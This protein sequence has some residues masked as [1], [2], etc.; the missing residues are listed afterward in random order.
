[1]ALVGAAT[2]YRYI[3]CDSIH[4]KK[5]VESSD[6]RLVEQLA[7]SAGW[8]WSGDRWTCPGC[9]EKWK[10]TQQPILHVYKKATTFQ[11]EDTN[12]DVNHITYSG[13][14]DAARDWSSR[15]YQMEGLR[16]I[17]ESFSN[18]DKVLLALPTGS[19][20]TFVAAKWICDHVL[21]RGGKVIW[22]AHRIELLEQAYAT[23]TRLLHPSRPQRITWWAGGKPK[24]PSGNLVFVSIMAA[25][26]F[27]EMNADLLVIDEAHHE[28]ATT[29][30]SLQDVISSKKHLGLTATPQRLD[31]K[32]LGY[33]AIAYQ[34]TFMSLVN[35]GW[36]ARPE[37]VVPRTGLFFDLEQRMDDFSNDSL[38]RL[39]TDQRNEFI[40]R[41]WAEHADDYGKTLVFALNRTHARRLTDRFQSARPQAKVEYI[42]SGEGTATERTNKI[43]QF[44]H[45]E[46]DVL[47]NCMIFTEGFDCP[48]VK[49]ILI[50]RPTLSTTLYS[51]MVGRGSRTTA[52]K[53]FFYLVDFEDNLGK[54]QSTLIRPWILGD[55]L[56]SE[57]S[58]PK[59]RNKEPSYDELPDWA[60][61]EVDLSD[62]ELSTIAGYVSY[63]F[64]SGRADGF[65]VHEDDEEQFEKV[66]SQL[67]QSARLNDEDAMAPIAIASSRDLDTKRLSL[68][69]LV[70]AAMALVRDEATYVRLRKA[71]IPPEIM[72]FLSD[73]NL[74]DEQL[75]DLANEIYEVYAL[76]KHTD[77]EIS[78]NIVWKQ[79]YRA[80]RESFDEA[81]KEL[82]DNRSLRGYELNCFL[83]DSYERHL[84]DTH[85]SEYEW[86][87]FAVNRILDPEASILC[88]VDLD[89]SST[90]TRRLSE[91]TRGEEEKP[92]DPGRFT[93][94]PM[95]MDLSEEQVKFLDVSRALDQGDL[96]VD[97][98]SRLAESTK[99]LIDK[100]ERRPEVERAFLGNM[101][102]FLH[103]RVHFRDGGRKY[104]LG[105][106]KGTNALRYVSQ[107]AKC[108]YVNKRT[109]SRLTS[110]T[111][112]YE[113][114]VEYFTEIENIDTGKLVMHRS[115][116]E[117]RTEDIE[118]QAK[119]MD[120]IAQRL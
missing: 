50:S 53:K 69:G 44:R 36:L 13:S 92:P 68:Q 85:I 64:E 99:R 81:L 103:L 78:Q 119:I 33:E 26:S 110:C 93:D 24:D 12:D 41:H 11:T 83:R 16:S 49:T 7:L 25:K 31:D 56:K 73:A 80:E 100:L 98:P 19:G 89:S 94:S 35:E 51:Q 15:P 52:E 10:V 21:S 20:K 95:G 105:W 67:Q 23:F 114:L 38:A 117:L 9:I 42:V 76:L 82:D 109:L 45:G 28:P 70:S 77:D 43:D 63:K 14:I 104:L 65:L 88:P 118:A 86:G 113:S 74:S 1:M 40:A 96:S 91:D 17:T 66:W 22:V 5:K 34:K 18:H 58:A 97:V 59:V 79:V 8:K 60:K 32:Q 108:I 47:V 54:F 84:V 111:D 2:K 30:R 57:D 71:T 55:E 101:G 29:Y 120:Y 90:R 6:P 72:E 107:M 75:N 87:R 106:R 116:V 112:L 27:P 39:D 3:E 61:E 48:D 62:L 4:C 115:N 37:P 46:I 102:A